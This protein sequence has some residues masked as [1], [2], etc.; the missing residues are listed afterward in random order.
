MAHLVA[1]GLGTEIQ[2]PLDTSES[3]DRRVLG[4]RDFIERL[5]VVR[6]PPVPRQTLEQLIERVCVESGQDL[7][8]L[9]SAARSARLCAL[10][11]EIARRAVEERIATRS[12]VARALGRSVSAIS[13]ALEKARRK[14]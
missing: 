10:R 4:S 8:Q 2:S 1:A 7:G 9:R 5:P 3:A 11:T 14:R 13:Q 12:D 6:P